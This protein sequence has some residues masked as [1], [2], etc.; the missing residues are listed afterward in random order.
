MKKL[1]YQILHTI[2]QGSNETTEIRNLKML[3]VSVLLRE[4]KAMHKDTLIGLGPEFT[5]PVLYIIINRMFIAN[6]VIRDGTLKF[7][8]QDL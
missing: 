3:I 7:D 4:F 5:R 1:K 8:N 2:L 6:D